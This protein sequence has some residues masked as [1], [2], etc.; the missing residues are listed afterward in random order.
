MSCGTSKKILYFQ[1]AQVGKAQNAANPV[2]ITI[3]PKD[4]I[5][6]V[7]SSREPQLALMFNLPKVNYQ[8][9]NA[10]SIS[11]SNGEVLG[12]TVDSA[13]NIDFPFLGF[14]NVKGQTRE[15][16]AQFIK[17][18]LIDEDQIKD[19]VV[20]VEFINLRFSILGEVKSPGEYFIDHDNMTLTEAISMAGDLTIY[21]KRDGVYVYRNE[22]GSKTPYQIDLRS[23]KLFNSP[24]Y[25]LKQGD[26]IY[27]E[28]NKV[29]AGQ[30]TVNDN[31]V[32]SVSLW[33]SVASFLTTVGVLIFK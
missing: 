8:M 16:V 18:K 19:P 17:K 20:T 22:N 6:I 28:P 12:Y 30:S 2:D 27:V 4:K 31:N 29:R 11:N 26:L 23:A 33:I 13:G 24:V 15:Q 1:D 7:V 21:G 3:Q 14:L 25:Y 9:G 10:S 5:S 32:K